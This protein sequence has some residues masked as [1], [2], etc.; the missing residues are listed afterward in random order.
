MQ[1]PTDT[2]RGLGNKNWVELEKGNTWVYGVL[3][4][5]LWSLARNR[6]GGQYNSFLAQAFLSV[7]FLDVMYSTISLIVTA[8]WRADSG[9]RRTLP[10]G[11]GLG[12]IF[13]LD[14]LPLYT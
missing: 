8:S 2:D 7:N 10:L 1:G 13:R 11:G 12:K 14:R 4:K 9:Q 6:Q 5:Y 3:I